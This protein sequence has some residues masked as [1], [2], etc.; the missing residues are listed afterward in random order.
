MRVPR[1]DPEV[2]VEGDGR[3]AAEG[4]RP[5][6][7]ALADHAGHVVFEV[8]VVHPEATS[9]ARPAPESSNSMI[10]AVSRRALEVLASTGREQ[11][12][13]RL[14]G[15][16]RDR[17]LGAGRRLHLGHRVGRDLALVLQPGV[18]HLE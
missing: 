2:A 18:E 8:Q 16:D 15:Q 10:M 13:Q 6:P 1:P 5:L 12:P 11:P 17:L 3:L 14:I 9:S 7:P 4:Q